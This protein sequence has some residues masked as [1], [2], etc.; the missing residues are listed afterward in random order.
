M[1]CLNPQYFWVASINPSTGGCISTHHD[2]GENDYTHAILVHT[3]A[4]IT[5]LVEFCGRKL[6]L[7][8]P[9][10]SNTSALL[11]RQTISPQH[12]YISTS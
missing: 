4:F 8:G 3:L 11:T 7:G 5:H 1:T 10:S 6:Q 2:T 12:L 9:H